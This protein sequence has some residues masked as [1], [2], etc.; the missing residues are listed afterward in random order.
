MKQI[1][2]IILSCLLAFE[3]AGQ[4]VSAEKEKLIDIS[5]GNGSIE[6]R[7]RS[8]E[9][10]FYSPGGVFVDSTGGLYFIQNFR[11]KPILRFYNGVLSALPVPTNVP[12]TWFGPST[13]GVSQNGV[14]GA[15]SFFF[16]FEND[17]YRQTDF[18]NSHLMKPVVANGYPTPWGAICE[19]IDNQFLVSAEFRIGEIAT[20]R[21]SKETRAWLPT[22]PGGFSIGDDGFLYRNGVLW[23]AVKPRG[24]DNF[25]WRYLGRLISGHAMWCPSPQEVA[26]TFTIVNAQGNIELTVEV[27]VQSRFNY[28]LG[29]WG[30][31]YYLFAPPMDKSL[32][33]MNDYYR[34]EPGVPAE[35]VVFRNHLKYFGRL[36][37]GDVRLRSTP[38]TSGEILGSYPNKT[39]FR[40]LER[41]GKIETIAGMTSD[42][43]KVRLLDGTE[44]WFFGAFVHNLYD[45]PNGNPP[46]W[47]NVPDW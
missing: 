45:G 34:P 43:V 5:V 13:S 28:G 7:Y 21:D 24:K 33:P 46:P 26:N 47:P 9:E 16:K 20:V 31:L 30:E 14:S 37:D 44:G 19:S 23:S 11:S 3:V 36:N 12:D 40:I 41:N 22:Q 4:T 42:W 1:I 15:G 17:S 29:P 2:L 6:A 10:G 27:P 8:T 18:Y 39:G 32:D 38:N 25:D 35:L